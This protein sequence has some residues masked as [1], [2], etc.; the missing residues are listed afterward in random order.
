M[1]TTFNIYES[2]ET[3]EGLHLQK[4]VTILLKKRLIL[5]NLPTEILAPV[6]RPN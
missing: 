4:G 5:N 3:V 6:N 1:I 2:L